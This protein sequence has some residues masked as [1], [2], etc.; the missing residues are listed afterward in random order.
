MSNKT[1]TIHINDQ[2]RIINPEVVLRWGYPMSKEDAKKLITKEQRDSILNMMKS[3]GCSSIRN[4]FSLLEELN[5]DN[6]EDYRKI[7]D[8]M[9]YRILVQKKFGGKERKLFTIQKES[10]RNK[11]GI[12]MD[13]KCVKTGVYH[14][15]RG[16]YC[17]YNEGTKC[18][19]GG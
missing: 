8:L 6:D 17:S 2:V 3:F 4:E 10:L 18:Y 7:L 15:G 14:T 12:I 9:A 13:R 19:K 16:N 11:T 1:D 5:E